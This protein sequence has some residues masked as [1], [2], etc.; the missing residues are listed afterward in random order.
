MFGKTMSISDEL[1]GRWY[2]LLFNEKPAGHPM[3]AK[4][5]LARRIVAQYHGEGAAQQALADFEKR[6]SKKDYS[7]ASTLAVPAEMWI[8]EL[9]EKTGKFKSRGDIRRLIQ[10]GGV[11]LD[12]QK[13]TD[14]KARV[15][16]QT[17]QLLKAGKLVVA[18][19]EVQ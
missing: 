11:T 10:G 9:V 19:L 7:D 18:R 12:G 15:R 14:D 17:G 13:I 4:K 16:L 1:M 3:V 8:V 5:E 6:F 2:Q